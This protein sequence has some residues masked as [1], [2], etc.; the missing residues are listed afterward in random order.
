MRDVLEELLD[1]TGQEDE[2]GVLEQLLRLFRV[3]AGNGANRA[4]I[5]E[6]ARSYAPEQ[7]GEEPVDAQQSQEELAQWWEE[8]PDIRLE[9]ED[10]RLAAAAARLTQGLP[11]ERWATGGAAEDSA[12]RQGGTAP[13]ADFFLSVNAAPA[14][15]QQL[16]Q[17]SRAAVRAAGAAGGGNASAR[18]EA[19]LGQHTSGGTLSGAREIDRAFERDAR[20]YDSRFYLY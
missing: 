7:T 19:P 13:E 1:A 10:K 3:R 11:G 14:L 6:E 5:T 2:G 17:R 9:Q 8:I 20:R 4:Q 16:E 12:A 18:A 15:T